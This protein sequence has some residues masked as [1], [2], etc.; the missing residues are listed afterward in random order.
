M[1]HSQQYVVLH[2]AVSGVDLLLLLDS[3]GDHT[4][5]VVEPGGDLHLGLQGGQALQVVFDESGRHRPLV[6]PPQPGW[7][8][9]VY[10]AS[11][12]WQHLGGRQRQSESK[13]GAFVESGLVLPEQASGELRKQRFR[14][15]RVHIRLEEAYTIGENRSPP[16]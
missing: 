11:P 5:G 14:V 10:A 13:C 4:R 15:M 3:R 16:L 7:A 2:H 8:A 6:R 9:D 12:E 1:S